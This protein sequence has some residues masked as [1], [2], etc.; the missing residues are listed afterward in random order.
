MVSMPA[1]M[2]RARA[3]GEFAT[4]KD[5][6]QHRQDL[7]GPAMNGRVIDLHS[8]FCHHLLD[9]RRLDG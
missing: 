8:A 4:T 2:A 3:F 5:R 1:R 9:V 7:D 6:R